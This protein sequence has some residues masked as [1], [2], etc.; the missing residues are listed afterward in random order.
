MSQYVFI[1]EMGSNLGMTRLYGRA[2]PGQ[3][4]YDEVPGDRGGNVSTIGALGLE[5][6]RTGLSVPGS[7][8]SD[9][10]L[11]FVEELLVPTLKRG[12]IV[13]MD[14]NPTHKLEEIED[15][16]DAA[17]AWVLF[18]PTYSP[19]LNPIEHCWS[20]VKSLLRSLKPRTLDDLL[21]ALAAAFSS[22]TTLD[23]LGWF[24]HCGYRVAST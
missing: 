11:F 24:R 21:A 22:I 14:N 10:M 13:V 7:S 12:D 1:D 4:V 19:D 18:L 2:A 5:G 16:I 17:G 20:K 3:R 23:I 6:M 8:D 9:T 15:A